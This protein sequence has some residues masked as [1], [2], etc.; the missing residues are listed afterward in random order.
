M[1]DI[2]IR[3][4]EYDFDQQGETADV[5]FDLEAMRM[6]EGYN[7]K[8]YENDIAVLKLNRPVAFTKSVYPICFPTR[9]E[10]FTNRRAYVVG[11]PFNLIHALPKI[12]PEKSRK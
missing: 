6:H 7:A 2:K 4:G 9:T 12:S 10:K 1:K 5:T 3:V 11:K 8:T